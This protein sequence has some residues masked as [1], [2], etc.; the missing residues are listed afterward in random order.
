MGISA[1]SLSTETLSGGSDVGKEMTFQPSSPVELL[2][3][4]PRTRY[5]AGLIGGTL[6]LFVLFS[7]AIFAL[8]NSFGPTLSPKDYTLL[9]A[10]QE[11][12]IVSILGY[13]ACY[14]LL[15]APPLGT[16]EISPAGLGIDGGFRRISYPWSRV[17]RVGR[18]LYTFS[19]GFGPPG[20]FVM[21]ESQAAPISR[22]LPPSPAEER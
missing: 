9:S 19:S 6:A 10:L 21:T 14:V 17:H 16:V 2:P 13:L 4:P 3:G 18:R 8:T 5:H 7:L 1:M 12:A 15:I 20:R 22:F 11:I